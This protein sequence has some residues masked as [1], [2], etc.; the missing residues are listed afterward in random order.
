MIY[1]CKHCMYCMQVKS[2]TSLLLNIG[3]RG[4]CIPGSN[5][6]GI[7]FEQVNPDDC[8]LISSDLGLNQ[9][10]SH[11]MPFHHSE[12]LFHIRARFCKRLQ[13][14]GIESGE[15]ILP[16]YVAWRAG[17]TNRVVIPARQA[18]NRFLG[19]LKSLQIR[20]LISPILNLLTM[21]QIM[22]KL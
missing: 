8:S 9:C 4:S 16:V 6:Q 20:A 5:I 12:V 18:G 13:I 15:S 19:S 2:Y 11:P 17:T 3:L 10:I 14:P 21:W 1:V 22:R 7:V